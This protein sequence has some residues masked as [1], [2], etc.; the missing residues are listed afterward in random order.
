MTVLP[1]TSRAS[2]RGGGSP[3]SPPPPLHDVWL[4]HG[5]GSNPSFRDASEFVGL[6]KRRLADE[7]AYSSFIT[8][9]QWCECPC[10]R[11]LSLSLSRARAPPS[12]WHLRRH[13]LARAECLGAATGSSDHR[14]DSRLAAACP[15]AAASL[16]S[17]TTSCRCL[18]GRAAV[19]ADHK[20]KAGQ[21]H[22]RRTMLLDAALVL[23]VNERVAVLFKDHPDL[24]GG[25]KEFLPEAAVAMAG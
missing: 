16:W 23:E 8:I 6:V 20:I 5:R 15:T 19:R 25:W 24:L 7:Q 14:L 13:S 17:T 1:P 21:G 10:I 4:P 22:A 2:P 11:S 18:T 12:P 9:L 3:L